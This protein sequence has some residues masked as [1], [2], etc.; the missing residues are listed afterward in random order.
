MNEEGLR[1]L[2][3]DPVG[4]L[5]AFI[6][7]QAQQVKWFATYN[8]D[9]RPGPNIRS[10]RLNA[11]ITYRGL[12]QSATGPVAEIGTGVLSP[13]KNFNYPLALE[14]GMAGPAGHLPTFKNGRTQGRYHYPFLEPALR[15]V[16]VGFS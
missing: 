15:E 8:T 9:G 4:P 5:G 3:Y 10:G 1:H 2:L 12:Q 6:H 7:T 16:F 13:R 11:S 14:K